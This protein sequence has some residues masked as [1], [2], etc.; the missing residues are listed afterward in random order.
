MLYSNMWI[1][2]TL[3]IVQTRRYIWTHT[4]HV[5][6]RVHLSVSSRSRGHSESQWR[7]NDEDTEHIY[8]KHLSV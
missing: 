5:I 3:Y 4:V 6:V 1:L 2:P 8:S 7:L